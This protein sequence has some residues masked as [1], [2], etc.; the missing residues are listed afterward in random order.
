MSA[1][2]GM[3]P[4]WDVVASN[5]FK[6]V[7]TPVN[8]ETFWDGWLFS[9]KPNASE[10]AQLQGIVSERSIFYQ[11]DLYE[12]SSDDA[13]PT[14]RT[15]ITIGSAGETHYLYKADG[16]PDKDVI[17]F[18]ATA[19]TAYT[20]TTS[21]LKNG[22]DTYLRLL[23]PDGTTEVSANDNSNGLSYNTLPFNCT[24]D[25]VCH[26]NGSNLLASKISFTASADGKYFVEVSASPSRPVS[27]GRYG[28]YTLTITSP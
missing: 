4:V 20:I 12:A 2:F 21:N 23:A 17:P 18:T 16:T 26:E 13:T 3:Q 19:G 14:T 25:G 15:P 24:P 8:M 9:R 7:T 6:A 11:E 10:I 27:A 22:A 5:Y 1:S 28:S